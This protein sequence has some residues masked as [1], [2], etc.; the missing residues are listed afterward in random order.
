M[1]V[2]E[3]L[4]GVQL[5][6][7][8]DLAGRFL[9]GATPLSEDEAGEILNRVAPGNPLSPLDA[10]RFF[11]TDDPNITALMI[12]R[13]GELKRTLFGKRIVLFAPLYISS[14]CHNNCIYCG[15]RRDN[16]SRQEITLSPEE[17]AR[18]ASLL[19]AKGYRRLLLVCGESAG[20]GQADYIADVMM[21]IY[22]TTGIRMLHL[23]SAPMPVADLRK[24]KEAGAGVYQVF[25]ET[26]H[27]RAY[28]EMH[29]SGKKA[30]YLW[31][32]SCMDRAV[33]AGFDDVGIGVLFGLYDWKFDAIA[34]VLHATYLRE[35]YGFWPHT[36]SVPRFTYAPGAMLLSPPHPVS[37]TDFL[38]IVAAYR[39]CV[40]AAGVVV[41]TR[42]PGWLREKALHAGASQISAGS[43]TSPGGYA[44]P[45]HSGKGEQFTVEDKR[46]LDE[47]IEALIDGSH[48]PSLCTSC[49]RSGRTGQR[50]TGIATEGKISDICHV[51]ALLSLA[52]H[53][54]G[55]EDESLAGKCLD[56][57]RRE[58]A[59]VAPHLEEEFQR[60]LQSVLG[61]EKDRKF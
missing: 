38:R 20:P 48:I 34:T 44:R 58:S 18:E 2:R 52:E 46:S 43:Q 19:M 35:R 57:V 31:R 51:N 4:K 50:F 10:S 37:D 29:P 28:Q 42:E 24:I 54:V 55:L 47:M 6:G 60:Q 7:I 36:L 32:L 17:A 9:S 3:T 14:R 45:T 25:Q 59:S 56:L 40:P 27:R 33:Q 1:L 49:Y 5:E 16:P 15:F 26:Y 23:N 41:S 13:A 53:A 11:L 21:S 61:G 39:L 22:G 12:E 30:D 8:E